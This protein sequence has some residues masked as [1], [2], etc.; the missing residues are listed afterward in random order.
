LYD[1]FDNLENTMTNAFGYAR[2]INNQYKQSATDYIDLKHRWDEALMHYPV[3]VQKDLTKRLDRALRSIER[4]FK[5]IRS[6]NELHLPRSV[7]LALANIVI[8]T[9][10]QR[11]L[12]PHWVIE[13]LEKWLP[14]RVL[15]LLVG[16]VTESELAESMHSL[17][18]IERAWACWEGQ[19]TAMA[20]YFVALALR[21]N[22]KD[23]TVPVAVYDYSL[24]PDIRANFIAISTPE[25]KRHMDHIDI[26]RQ[27][28]FGV[29][30]DNSE[31]PSWKRLAERQ[32]ILQKHN[33]FL[34]DSKFNDQHMPGAITRVEDIMHEK[35]YTNYT[36]EMFGVYADVILENNP[37]AINTKEFPIIAQFIQLAENSGYTYTEEEIQG[38]ARM[39]LDLFDADFEDRFWDKVKVAFTVAWSDKLESANSRMARPNFGKNEKNGGI[40]FYWQVDK[41]WKNYLDHEPAM[42]PVNIAANW[43]P[44]DEDL[45]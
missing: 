43:D 26:Y 18:G 40:F 35:K 38:L 19:H 13:I 5:G 31:D 30:V 15:P 11:R 23:F 4:R 34:T 24:K 27:K 1:G 37:R 45:F 2:S 33:L 29:N 20:L 12:E 36:L 14:Q 9:T 6:S 7:T 3:K 8:D 10:I 25:G 16:E 32:E 17:Y 39:C 22:P 21:I 28:V 41:S 42:P 44:R